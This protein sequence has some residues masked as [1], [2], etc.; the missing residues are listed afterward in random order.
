MPVTSAPIS[1][2]EQSYAFAI[3]SEPILTVYSEADGAGGIG[4]KSIQIT[5]DISGSNILADTLYF[6]DGDTGFYESD[7][8]VIQ[9][10]IGG[11]DR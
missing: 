4:N 2:N 8:D 1:G 6:G 9:I 11:N 10:S 5:G 7:D 3:N